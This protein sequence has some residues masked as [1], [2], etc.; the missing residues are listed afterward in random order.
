M[1]LSPNLKEQL[2]L[3]RL[4]NNTL[5]DTYLGELRLRNLSPY[6]IKKV[7]ELLRTFKDFLN[8]EQPTPL[9]AKTFLSQY[10]SRKPNT[11]VTYFTYV[12]GFMTWFG[13]PLD[14]RPKPPHNT[15]PYHTREQIRSLANAI[16]DKKT[17]KKFGRRDALIIELAT[18]TG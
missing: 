10:V 15:P 4:D 11:V 18:N 16:K 17:H 14:Y 8:G 9:L 6:Y 12:N 1:L 13:S 3:R 5:F 2:R 7:W